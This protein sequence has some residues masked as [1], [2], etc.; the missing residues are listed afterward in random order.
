MTPSAQLVDVN[1]AVVAAAVDDHRRDLATRF[2]LK[3]CPDPRIL[4]VLRGLGAPGTPGSVGID[5]CSPGEVTHALANGWEPF[6]ISHTGTNVSDRDLDVL[7][8]DP[9]RGIPTHVFIGPDGKVREVRIGTHSK[10]DM[11]RA[12]PVLRV[13]QCARCHTEPVLAGCFSAQSL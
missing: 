13:L 5:A 10:D 3:S 11:A 9:I 8:A 4:A 2:A 7:L 1:Q 6:E 12:V